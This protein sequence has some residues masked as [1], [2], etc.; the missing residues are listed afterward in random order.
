[1]TSPTRN[2]RKL[3]PVY[4]VTPKNDMY[5][6][7]L[8]ATGSCWCCPDKD[9]DDPDEIFYHHHAYDRR[10]EYEEGLRKPH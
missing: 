5:Q 9:D 1:M 7:K 8:D 4:H 6:H 3:V 10:D 2:G